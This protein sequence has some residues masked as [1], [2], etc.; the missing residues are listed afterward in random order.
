MD[1]VPNHV[2]RDYGKSGFLPG[3]PLLGGD[4]DKSVHWKA[5]NDFFYYPGQCLKLPV[6]VP[7]GMSPYVE[8]PAMATGNNCYNPEP[9]INDWYETGLRSGRSALTFSRLSPGKSRTCSGA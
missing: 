1:F 6:A 8:C 4:D 3:H 5:E 9:G 2:S 7:E